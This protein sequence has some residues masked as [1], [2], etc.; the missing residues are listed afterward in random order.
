MPYEDAGKTL[1]LNGLPSPLTLRLFS[2]NPATGGAEVV[3]NGYAA[4][5]A[6]F[7]AAGA[8]AP[9]ERRLAADVDFGFSTS[10]PWTVA[11]HIGLYNGATLVAWDE[12][13]EP[14]TANANTKIVF[15]VASPDV[16]LFLTDF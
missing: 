6:S 12:L 10:G 3:G 4:Q 7:S 9:N 8:V 1:L 13:A 11:S 15:R 2:G 16:R 5:T 14:K